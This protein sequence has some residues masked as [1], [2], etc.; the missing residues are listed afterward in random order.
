M[1][2]LREREKTLPNATIEGNGEGLA[3]G[4]GATISGGGRRDGQAQGLRWE[5]RFPFS[6]ILPGRMLTNSRS[7]LAIARDRVIS[8]AR[9]HSRTNTQA[10]PAARQ[11]GEEVKR[12]RIKICRTACISRLSRVSHAE[13]SE[14]KRLASE[15]TRS[16]ASPP[17][18]NMT[19][20]FSTLLKQ[21]AT[22][23]TP[24]PGRS[25]WASPWPR[26]EGSF[27]S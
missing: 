1:L 6:G 15:I 25:R 18:V 27:W 14:G 2:V 21:F 13:R 9:P 16:P 19:R 7:A 12:E 22:G 8:S 17:S 24:R 10:G 3:E 20:F 26:L 5:A 4:I 11:A 23:A